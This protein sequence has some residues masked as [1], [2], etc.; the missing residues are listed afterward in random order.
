MKKYII[1]SL[2]VLIGV[3]QIEAQHA[4]P[5][6][7]F[8]KNIHNFGEVKEDGG[9]KTFEFKFKNTGGQPLVVHNVKASCGCTTPQWT[10]TPIP[11]GGSGYVRAIFDPRNRPGTF[12]KTI[13]VSSNAQNATIILRING[14]VLPREMTTADIY[15]RNMEKIRLETS[16]LAFTSM[17]PNQVKEESIKII[18]TSDKAIKLGFLNVPSHIKIK[19]IPEIVQPG[20]AAVITA[21]YDA[22]AKNDWGFVTDNIFIIFDD[23]RKYS[24]RIT[25]SA[26]IQEDFAS[27]DAEKIK[28]APVVNI[29]EKNWNFGEI[30]QGDVVKHQF[31]VQNTGKSELII[32]KVK[33]SCGC[34]AIKPAKTIL[35][36]GESTLIAAEFNSR[37]KSGRQTKTV[38]IVSNDPKNT[39]ITL[40]ITGNVKIN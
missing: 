18:S 4:K 12:N 27:W 15:P 6:L 32:R 40:M 2:L 17:T 3:S 38:R 1:L 39:T 25:V 36:P 31:E 21:S 14:K 26:S 28:N 29:S 19:C 8:E 13:T 30:K 5:N 37:G 9:T 35:A 10:R 23:V 34:T 33:A 16:H 7:A 20:K 22:K 11:P 24:N